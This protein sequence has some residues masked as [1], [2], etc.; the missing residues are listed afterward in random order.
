MSGGLAQ[1]YVNPLTPNLCF[2][3]SSEVLPATYTCTGCDMAIKSITKSRNLK[4]GASQGFEFL[5]HI[6]WAL[7]NQQMIAV[8]EDFLRCVTNHVVY[9]IGEL[10]FIVHHEKHLQFN[11]ERFPPTFDSTRQHIKR[12]YL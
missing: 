10:R 6:S 12:A 1:I 8:A 3:L 2:K 4:E 7:F 9:T 5:Y 11:I